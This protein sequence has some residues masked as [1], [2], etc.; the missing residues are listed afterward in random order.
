MTLDLSDIC[1]AD[2][3]QTS[4]MKILCYIVENRHAIVSLV[5]RDILKWLDL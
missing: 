4:R 5:P 2:T 3:T 1:K